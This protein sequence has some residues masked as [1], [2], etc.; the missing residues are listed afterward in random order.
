MKRYFLFFWDFTNVS[1]IK[2]VIST[3]KC[4]YKLFSSACFC[5]Y[6][7]LSLF[8]KDQNLNFRGT[9]GYGDSCLEFLFHHFKVSELYA[10]LHDAAGV[11]PAHSFKEPG[12]C[13][14]VGRR[15][16]VGL[17]GLLFC[18][19][20]KF[21]PRSIFNTA[22]LWG[23]MSCIVLDFELADESFH[24][25][26]VVFIDGSVRGNAFPSP[27]KNK[28]TKQASCSTTNW[29]GIAWERGRLDYSELPKSFRRSVKGELFERRTE[30]C[31]TVG[32]SM[33]N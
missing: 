20:V 23:T 7:R 27:K 19:R 30:K 9:I 18:L 2:T 5:W 14:M 26:L 4:L 32:I 31:K 3:Q 28:S 16:K 1:R 21:F 13:N 15:P 11:V 12:Y 29:H 10:V 25:E 22:D 17:L 6:F 33:D 24:K 8:G